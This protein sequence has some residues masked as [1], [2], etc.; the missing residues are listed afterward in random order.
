MDNPSPQD[1]LFRMVSGYWISQAIY[2]AAELRIA[3]RLG[4]SAMTALELA[5]RTGAQPQ[6][7]YRLLRALASVG[8]FVEDAGHH[9]RATPLSNCLRSDAANSQLAAVL[10]MVGQFYDAWGGLESSI[11][12]GEPAFKMRNGMSFFDHLTA[13]PAQARIFDAAMTALNDRK[14]TAFLDA[15]DLADVRILAD[16]GGGNGSALLRILKRYPA[17]TGILFDL[18]SV[19]D[20]AKVDLERSDVT[21]RCRIVSGSFF[22]QVPPGADIYLLRHIIHNWDD[23]RAAVILANI[24][25]AMAGDSKLVVVE[26]IIPPGNEPSYG[27]FADLNMLIL[28]GGL[29]RSAEE[30][31]RLFDT[32][33]FRLTKIVPTITEVSVIEGMKL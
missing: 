14:T 16:V 4:D 15:Y 18:P 33:G 23:E 2:V 19:V 29:E 5:D 20:R 11:K 28:H 30:F 12:S 3:D 1:Q 17:M 13:N 22:E 7:L 26:R 9:F 10:M 21:D 25:Q 24:H 32:A 8:V 6:S 27:K 31:E